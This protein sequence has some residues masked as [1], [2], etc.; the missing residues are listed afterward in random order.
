VACPQLN[1]VLACAVEALFWL[2]AWRKEVAGDDDAFFLASTLITSLSGVL[3]RA[4][5]TPPSDSILVGLLVDAL[6]SD[7][8]KVC[9]RWWVGGGWRD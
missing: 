7:Y 8:H 5:K 4:S 6:F 9:V 2:L 3:V 1:E